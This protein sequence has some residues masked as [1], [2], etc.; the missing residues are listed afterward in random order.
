M[1]VSVVF[2]F[3]DEESNIT[4]LINRVRKVFLKI[5][6]DYEFIFVNDDSTDRSLELLQQARATD[7]KIKI[8]SMSRCFGVSP[9]VLAGMK[10]S[11]GDAVVYMDSDL[12][13]P[14]ELIEKMITQWQAG[15]EVVHTTR[16]KRH[17]E[18]PLKMMVTGWAYKAINYVSE[19]NIKENT[20]DFKLLSR[21]VVEQILRLDEHDPFMRGL[22]VWVG[23]KQ[24]HI[25]Y[26]REARFAGE[27]H[28]SIFSKGPTKEF[29]RG[30]VSYSSSPLYLS[31]Y[32]GL[33]TCLVSAFLIVYALVIKVLGV[34]GQGI[35]SI[36]IAISFFSGITMV[37][38]GIMGL[39]IAKIYEQLKGRPRYIIADTEGFDTSDKT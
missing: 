15:F 13:D 3:R 7:D 16:T 2:S 29:I 8:I 9:C 18:H 33:L 20:G 5:K 6:I 30:I 24:T 22:P 4:E 27:A 36:I 1:L 32:L 38:N 23:F 34:S 21:K 25:Y 10:Y 39:Y 11:T 31:F 19:I 37:I 35:P 14:P 17:G 28:F 12:Q 26:E